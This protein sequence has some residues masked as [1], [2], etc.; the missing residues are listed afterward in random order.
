MAF[1]VRRTHQLELQTVRVGEYEHLLAKPRSS[2][3]SKSMSALDNFST[4]APIEFRGIAKEV[5]VTWPLPFLPRRAPGQ[6]KKVIIVPGC[7]IVIAVV[8]VIRCQDR[9]N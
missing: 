6:G 3:P 9:R 2:D 8:E 4:Q 1:V 5:T 7:A